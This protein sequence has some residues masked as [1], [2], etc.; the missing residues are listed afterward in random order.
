MSMSDKAGLGKSW[1]DTVKQARE[2]ARKEKES[3]TKKGE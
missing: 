1:A 3:E 2:E